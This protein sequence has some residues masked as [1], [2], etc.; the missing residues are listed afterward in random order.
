MSM[1]Q[2]ASYKDSGIEWMGMIPTHWK[3]CKVKNLCS[4]IFAGG[5]P[6][7]NID[8]YWDG[9][10]PWIPSG[11]CHDCNIDNAPKTITEEGLSNSST[12]LI[13]ANTTVMAMTGATC[14]M[15]G[16][17]T[18]KSC[19]NQSVAAFIGKQNLLDSR[20]LF[21]LLQGMRRYILTFQTGGAQGGINVNDCQN[22]I[23]PHIPVE[24]Q[25]IIALY[26]DNK[27]SQIDAIIAEKEKMVEDLQSYRKSII[28]ET[29]TR[30]LNPDVPMKDSGIEWIGMMPE[31][32]DCAMLKYYLAQPL[33]YGA[34]ESAEFENRDWPRYIRITDIK[35]TG[36]LKDETFKSLP[37][38]KANDYLLEKGDILFARSG[39][40]V[41]KTYIFEENYPACFAGYLIK[42]KCDK[43]KLIPRYLYYYTCTNQYD[44]WKN[45]IFVQATIQNIGADKYSTMPILVPSTIKEQTMIVEKVETEIKSINQSITE[46]KLQIEDLRTYKTALITE[47]VT[48]KIDLR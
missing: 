3:L 38:N 9:E 11:C 41:G 47:A 25:R 12:R 5:T 31:H 28:S 2:Y 15:V 8:S 29:I 1:K 30:G 36:E 43:R 26:L 33:Q 14:S 35:E 16:Y 48:G 34:N 32:W 24:E 10:I 4:E 22:L 42:A 6:S 46:L 13:P 17:L 44:N 19:A 23:I 27:V 18:F 40:T 39:A 45:S 21:Y 20:F 37:P 7:T